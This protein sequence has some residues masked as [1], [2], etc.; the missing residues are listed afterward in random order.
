MIHGLTDLREIMNPFEIHGLEHLSPS[1][2]NLFVASPAM[3]V[4]EKLMKKRSP[5]GAA[6]HRGTSVEEGIAQALNGATADVAVK[7]AQDKFSVLTA[8]SGDP[9][10]EKEEGAIADMVRVGMKELLPYGKPSSAQ[11]KIEYKVEGLAVPMI[12]FYDFEW[13][14]HGILID[15]KTTHALP[16]K[17]STNHARQVA[18]YCA[19]RGDNLD[20]RLCYVT[21][22]KSAVY[23]LENVRQ[24]VEAL[25]V[26][27]LTIQRFLSLSK[28]PHELAGI[29][30]PDVDSFYFADP[31]ARQAAFDIWRL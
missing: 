2:C 23:H 4:Q 21:P 10:R 24:H 14:D 9:R 27:A 29:V 17:I 1:T 15:L 3:F 7:A 25:G 28:D 31:L 13:A 26:I 22:K 12:G 11:G 18:L 16:S 8:L 5:V 30:C 20:A 19:A 6:A